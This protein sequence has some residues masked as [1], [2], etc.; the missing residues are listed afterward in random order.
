MHLVDDGHGPIHQQPGTGPDNE[1][2]IKAIP[3]KNNH[4]E[5]GRD[6]LCEVATE[7][8]PP[9]PVNPAAGG[10]DQLLALL[11]GG[12]GLVHRPP[13]GSEF[14]QIH[15]TISSRQWVSSKRHRT[16]WN[17][18]RYAPSE[19]PRTSAASAGDRPSRCKS[20]TAR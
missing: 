20:R 14:I 19:I 13:L 11:L 1:I 18:V 3:A 2:G 16:R 12:R 10:R 7:Y 17:R 15:G 5:H 9:E 6:G 8:P 4:H